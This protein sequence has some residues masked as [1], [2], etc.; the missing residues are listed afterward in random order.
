MI[1]GN[2]KPFQAEFNL[3]GEFSS[4]WTP[5]ELKGPWEECLGWSKEELSKIPF[6]S[7]I[8]PD[9][10]S[11]VLNLNYRQEPGHLQSIQCRNQCKNGDYKP[12]LWIFYVDPHTKLS[13][14]FGQ[15]LSDISTNEF[16]LEQ[17]QTVAR[18]GSWAYDVAK[19]KVYWTKGL[20]ALHGLDPQNFVPTKENI[21]EFYDDLNTGLFY[22][23]TQKLLDQD[24]LPEFDYETTAKKTDGSKIRVRIR[25]RVAT[26][27]ST[28]THIYGTTQDIT[29][30]RERE[31][32]LLAAKDEAEMANRIKSDF[33]ANISH[34]IRTPMNSIIGM[35]EV[36]SETNLDGDQ[37]QYIDVLSRSSGNLLRILND[38]LDLAKL[39]AGKIQFESVAFNLHDVIYRTVDLFNLRAK[40]KDIQLTVNIDSTLR[41]VMMGDPIRI[42]QVLTNL[43]GNALKFTDQ[44]SIVVRA[45][46]APYNPEFVQISVIDSGI[47][48]DSEAIPHLF[49]RFYQVDSSISR[50]YGGTGLGL[51]ISKELIERMGGGIAAESKKG[52]GSIFRFWLPIIKS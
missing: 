51:S 2:A 11:L 29:K 33:L 6:Y 17:S 18:I 38:V 50:K 12:I 15:D 47:G 4:S 25:C 45:E 3:S 43:I 20:Y 1:F 49:K 5:I 28:I 31:Q 26:H 9:D 42:G 16:L 36:L 8:H 14:V 39:E 23:Q 40:E 32:A 37:R 46:R 34:E 21:L 30:E 35:L 7:L 27:D 22:E 19:G 48:I 13:H 10:L 24:A 41:A 52:A 44:G